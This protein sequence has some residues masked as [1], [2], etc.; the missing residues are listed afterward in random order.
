MTRENILQNRMMRMRQLTEYC[1]LS[2][3]YIYQKIAEGEFPP[4]SMISSG[5]RIWDRAIV[6][7]WLDEKM[8]R[9]L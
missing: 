3:A 8:G 9:N 1:A 7:S 4:G 2:R 5:I 6:D